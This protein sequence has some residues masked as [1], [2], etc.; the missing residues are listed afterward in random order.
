[1]S[2]HG[3]LAVVGSTD[4]GLI[5]VELKGSGRD[6]GAALRTRRLEVRGDPIT[7][8]SGCSNF[9]ARLVGVKLRDKLPSHGSWPT[10]C[11]ASGSR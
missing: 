4:H 11:P 5:E 8:M 9:A 1:M 7:A 6:P 2:V 10:A 3:D